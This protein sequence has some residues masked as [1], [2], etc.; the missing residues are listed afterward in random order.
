MFAK[1]VVKDL[2]LTLIE[3]DCAR[4]CAPRQP[5]LRCDAHFE[6]VEAS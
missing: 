6:Q 4:W 2:F 1:S 5:L 3:L